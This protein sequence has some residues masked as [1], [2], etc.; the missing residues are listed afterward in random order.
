MDDAAV[1][2]LS[3]MVAAEFRPV[4]AAKAA[5]IRLPAKSINRLRIRLLAAGSE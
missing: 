5:L 1:L 4:F 3:G 2:T